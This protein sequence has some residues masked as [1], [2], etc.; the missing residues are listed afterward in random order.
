MNRNKWREC[1]RCIRVMAQRHCKSR[2]KTS[3]MPCSPASTFMCSIVN[4]VEQ[5]H[6][7][8]TAGLRACSVLMGQSYAQSRM[9]V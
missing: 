1:Y 8:V 5:R 9:Y 2:R 3:F 7:L 6:L 4:D